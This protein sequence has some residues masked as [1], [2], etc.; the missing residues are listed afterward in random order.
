MAEVARFIPLNFERMS[1]QTQLDRS[2]TFL[3]HMRRR[4]TV[5]HFSTE[6]VPFE[7]I[8]NAIATAGSAPSGANQQPWTFVVVSDPKIKR[9]IRIAAEAEE[10]ESY[11]RR[12][13]D[14]WLEALAPLGTDWHKPHLEEAPYLIVVFRQSYGLKIDPKT[15]EKIRIKHYY[16]E[17]SVGIAVGFLLASLHHAGLATL[18][19]TPSPMGFLREILGRPENERPFVLIPVGYPA[20]DAQVPEIQKKSLDEI[21]VVIGDELNTQ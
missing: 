19:H 12:M 3:E 4:R 21:M 15:G 9:Q 16:S 13:S 18:T 11:E 2:R 14:E 8:Q 17:E 20:A 6:S 5:R 1:V 7:L 10:K